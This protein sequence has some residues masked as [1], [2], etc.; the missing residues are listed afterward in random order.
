MGF[1]PFSKS[2]PKF[3][4]KALEEMAQLYLTKSDTPGSELLNSSKL[5]FSEESLVIIDQYLAVMRQ[6]NLEGESLMKFVFRCG[7]YVGEVV[8]RNAKDS[9]YH[10]IDFPTA[11]KL[12]K[13]KHIA[14]LAEGLGTVAILWDGKREFWFPFGK[15]IKFLQNG[16]EDSVKHFARFI[17]SNRINAQPDISIN[18]N[19]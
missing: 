18:L 14:S 13:D 11:A 19:A 10:W 6:K 5:D 17:I 7:A 8:R 4:D 12:D 3:Q 16:Q 1:W 2:T 9:E 15:V